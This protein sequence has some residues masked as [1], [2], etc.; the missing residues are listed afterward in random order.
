MLIDLLYVFI[1]SWFFYCFFYCMVAI[2]KS[3]LAGDFVSMECR[4]LMEE[5][6]VEIVP[7]YMIAEKVKQAYLS[8]SQM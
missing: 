4:K 6:K 8:C 2:V 5:H 3:P 7:S 1:E